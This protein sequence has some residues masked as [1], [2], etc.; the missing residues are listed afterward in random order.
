MI[1][2]ENVTPKYLK[3]EVMD[4]IIYIGDPIYRKLK[5]KE[6]VHSEIARMEA[7]V[8]VGHYEYI[9]AV[10]L[11]ELVSQRRL[12]HHLLWKQFDEILR[13]DRFGYAAV[14][15]GLEKAYLESVDQQSHIHLYCPILM[16]FTDNIYWFMSGTRRTN[17]ALRYNEP[18]KFYVVDVPLQWSK[19]KP[20]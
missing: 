9:G 12:K 4:E 3:E 19:S 17:L 11:H 13:N 14:F 10:G 5:I 2:W 7:L 1:V 16:K 6:R 20:V 8:S 15:A 18:L